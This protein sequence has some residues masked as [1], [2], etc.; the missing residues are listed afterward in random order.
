MIHVVVILGSAL[1]E[2]RC[3]G[4][5]VGRWRAAAAG[6]LSFPCWERDAAAGVPV[7][8]FVRGAFHRCLRAM[9]TAATCAVLRRGPLVDIVAAVA[10]RHCW[11][12]ILTVM[13]LLPLP[14]LPFLERARFLVLQ[15]TIISVW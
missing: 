4:D 6:R 2:V 11:R 10:G 15:A 13:L 3:G 14:P 9:R 12:F 5:G 8:V 7:D 1:H